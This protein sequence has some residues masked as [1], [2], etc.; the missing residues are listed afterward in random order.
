[1]TNKITDKDI[2]EIKANYQEAVDNF[3]FRRVKK[4]VDVLEWKWS[5]G[6]QMI[7]PKIEDMYEV[8]DSLFEDLVKDL[9]IDNE[10][11]NYYNISTCGFTVEIGGDNHVEI[12]FT[13]E[14]SECYSEWL[15]EEETS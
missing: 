10:P 1:M 9:K 5:R 15:T 14:K 11:L 12:Q 6:G 2:K 7:I 13:V 3:D 8:V 4:C